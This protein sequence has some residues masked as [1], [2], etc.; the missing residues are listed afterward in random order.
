VKEPV[1]A[2][3]NA[4]VDPPVKAPVDARG[5]APAN[6]PADAP[7]IEVDQLVNRFG[8]QLVHDHLDLAV[9]RG[10]ILGLIGGSG[11]GKSVLVRTIL[12]LQ[13]PTSGRI[14]WFGQDVAELDDAA[15]LALEQRIG[16]LFQAGALFSSLTVL[17]NVLVP[18]KEYTKLD[19]DLAAALARLKLQL[20]GLS[21]DAAAKYPEQLSGGMRKR[22]GLAR[23]L[24][25]DPEV[26]FLDEPTSGLDPIGA[27]EFDVRL[28]T[29]HRALG[30]TVILITHDLDTIFAVCDRV[31]VLADGKVI[32]IDS[33]DV[34]ARHEHPWIRETFGGSR[35]TRAEQA[36]DGMR[37]KRAEQATDGKAVDGARGKS[38]EQAVSNHNSRAS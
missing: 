8:E 5:D 21:A 10:E 38:A 13:K 20:A 35:G 29:L 33:P 3:V 19:P 14:R 17:E 6:A 31:A 36:P 23:A 1:D 37:G 24:A 12:G 32:V 22:A 25:L 34:V 27:D 9:R 26:V 16:V 4:P 18:F 2:P 7:V 11:S 30:M 28:K 15:R